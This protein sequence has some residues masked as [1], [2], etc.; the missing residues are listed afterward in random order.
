MIARMSLNCHDRGI[1]DIG[2]NWLLET[3]E[4]KATHKKE[5]KQKQRNLLHK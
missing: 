5:Q 4:K 1:S 2:L 3:F